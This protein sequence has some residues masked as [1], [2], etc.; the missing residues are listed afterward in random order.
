MPQS[1][2]LG[3][4]FWCTEEMLCLVV[5]APVLVYCRPAK[6]LLLSWG[7]QTWHLPSGS[8]SLAAQP[9]ARELFMTSQALWFCSEMTPMESLKLLESQDFCRTRETYGTG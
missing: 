5:S 7:T 1:N 6:D 9:D 8:V 2:Q 4:K 3:G